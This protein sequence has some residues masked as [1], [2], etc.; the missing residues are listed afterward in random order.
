[1]II[2]SDDPAPKN[3]GRCLL[4]VT[5]TTGSIR[6]EILKAWLV[7]PTIQSTDVKGE[8]KTVVDAY[9]KSFKKTIKK[10]N[11][12]G[13]IAERFMP[14]GNTVQGG[15]TVSMMLGL[16]LD[17]LSINHKIKLTP[18]VSWKTQIKRYF[19]LKQLYKDIRPCPD[20]LLD[21]VLI[22][23]Y[24]AYFEFNV[25]PY[26]HMTEEDIKYIVKKLKRIGVVLRIIQKIKSKSKIK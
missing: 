2:L 20:H 11:P 24:L 23:L 16:N 8:I 5:N 6:F 10:H 22:G 25:K 12:D 14:R 4:S 18:A 3:Y 26:S 9:K 7:N 21:A 17:A 13:Y 19:D 15:E 1:M